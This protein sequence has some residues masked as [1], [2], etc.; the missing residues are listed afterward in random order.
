MTRTWW[1][2]AVFYQ[3]YPRSF[4]DAN[5][6]GIGDMNGMRQKL[7]YLAWLG[8][9]AIWLSPHFPSPQFD[10]GYDISD[11]CDVAPEYGT[12]DDFKQFLAEAHA[13]YIRVIL[14]FVL[15]HTSHLHAWFIE[16]RSSKDNPKR[17]WFIWRD[18]VGENP[19]NNWQSTFGGSAWEYDAQTGQYYYHFFLK[20]QPDLNWRNPEVVEAMFNAARFWLD[21]GV[22]GFRLDAVGTIFEQDDL[23]PHISKHRSVDF[24]RNEVEVKLGTAPKLFTGDDWADLFGTQVNLPEVHT[25]MK[26][27]RAVIDE[28]TDRVLIGETGD[29]IYLGDGTDELHMV[30]NFNLMTRDA[31]FTAEWI[32]ANLADQYA[33]LPAG[34]WMA[35]TL[36]NH[37]CTRAMS[38]FDDGTAPI[39]RAKLSATLMLTLEPTPFLYNG[40]EIG[41]S[42]YEIPHHDQMRDTLALLMGDLLIA[43]GHTLEE[44]YPA[45]QK[46][47]RDRC[48]TPMAWSNAPNGGFSPDGVTTW[49]P[50]HPEYA[51]G[52][53]V[54]DEQADPYSLLYFYKG[55]I[56]LRKNTPALLR[57]TYAPLDV[58]NEAIFAFTRQLDAQTCVVLLN[59]SA[60]SQAIT[61]DKLSIG[62]IFST[63]T[64]IGETLKGAYTLAPYS[65][66]I[67]MRK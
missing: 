30:F 28:Y 8:I 44:I 35:N 49:L 66:V 3:I 18:G 36:N 24:L 40:E 25:V 26:Q 59:F 16:S 54:A 67:A 43:D 5:G 27:L 15:N 21:M 47:S 31:P 58:K 63:D 13:R 64:P 38:R 12:L 7:D 34:G 29:M 56:A 62:V 42:N 11:Y 65:M 19:P 48:R 39:P 55:L 14:D 60:D 1:Q 9:D 45:M 22:D 50:V 20:E 41:M 33:Q 6:D 32:Y 53:N 2:D 23:S 17:D 46:M 51:D 4:A 52:V 57:G 37:D 61:L 10:C